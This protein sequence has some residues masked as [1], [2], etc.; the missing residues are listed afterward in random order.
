MGYKQRKR[1]FALRILEVPCWLIRRLNLVHLL[2]GLFLGAL[3]VNSRNEQRGSLGVC[4]LQNEGRAIELGGRKM[5]RGKLGRK[6]L[7]G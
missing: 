7:R 4:E 5:R 3:Q 2:E 1:L 6:K